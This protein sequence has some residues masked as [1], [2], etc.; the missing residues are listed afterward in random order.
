MNGVIVLRRFASFLPVLLVIGVLAPPARAAYPGANG[1]IAFERGGDIWVVEADGSNPRNVTNT[2]T[3]V[4]QHPVVSPDGTRIAYT[5]TEIYDEIYE[6]Y[7]L[8]HR[9][10]LK[11]ST[12]NESR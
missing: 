7:M 12:K 11:I 5:R 1:I 6:I 2:P 9:S 8:S 10:N 4:E 3:N